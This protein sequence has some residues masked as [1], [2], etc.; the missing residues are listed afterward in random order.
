MCKSNNLPINFGMCQKTIAFVNYDVRKAEMLTD[1]FPGLRP[2]WVDL[3]QLENTV[4]GNDKKLFVR[5][6]EWYQCF[7]GKS[8]TAKY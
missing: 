6:G 2:N 4:R 7:G 3:Q 8:E 5:D 1:E